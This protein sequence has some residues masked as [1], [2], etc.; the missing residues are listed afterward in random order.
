MT[1]QEIKNAVDDAKIV[2]WSNSGYRVVKDELGQY[3]IVFQPNKYTIGLTW[4]DGI[5]LNGKE[6]EFFILEHAKY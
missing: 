6:S 2:C 5:T 4:R 3:L 1:L